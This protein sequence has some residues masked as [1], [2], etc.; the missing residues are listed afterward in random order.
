MSDEP[1]Q[2]YIRLSTKGTLE[3]QNLQHVSIKRFLFWFMLGNCGG[4]VLAQFLTILPGFNNPKKKI[5]LKRYQR[6]AYAGTLF[7]LS[8]HGYSLTKMQFNQEKRK[9]IKDKS[10]LLEVETDSQDFANV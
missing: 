4:W 5:T 1:P 10:N 2:E 7:F 9:L 6:L 8:Y 3:Y